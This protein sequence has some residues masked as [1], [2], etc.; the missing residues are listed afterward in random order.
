M[1]KKNPAACVG[2]HAAGRAW[3]RHLLYREDDGQSTDG[4]HG[5]RFNVSA[6]QK[7]VFGSGVAAGTTFVHHVSSH[8]NAEVA[9][10]HRSIRRERVGADVCASDRSM[11]R[12]ERTGRI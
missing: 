9:A 2:G 3:R 12:G 11:P 6:V 8:T 1:A 7:K 10:D 5:N 4:K